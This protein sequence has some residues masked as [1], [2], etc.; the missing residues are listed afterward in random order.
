MNRRRF[1]WRWDTPAKYDQNLRNYFRMISG[2]DHEVGRVLATLRE[3]GLLE[4]TVVIYL[5]DNGYYLGERG[6][7]GKWSHYEESL[8][9]PM[10][11]A[12]APVRSLTA[13]T[14]PSTGRTHDA[15]VLNLDLAATVCD[16][17]G[18]PPGPFFAGR[19]L[20][21]LLRPL[22]HGEPPADW[23]NDFLVEH[24]MEHAEIPRWEGVRDTRWVYA[25]YI[26]QD[27]V[28]EFLHDLETD[29]DQLTNL[30]TESRFAATLERL[31]SRCDELIQQN[32]ITLPESKE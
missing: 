21:P 30:A 20:R 23:R 28:Y 17:A 27:P 14:P 24:L 32:G 10:I 19:S 25:R 5:A 6:L 7:A 3:R 12:D 11:I 8:R 26:D 22:L 4:Q 13:P 1:S 16:L 9:I 15:P 18:V 31:R 29:P 2:I